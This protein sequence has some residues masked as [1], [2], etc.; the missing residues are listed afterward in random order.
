MKNK[1]ID[2]LNCF[3]FPGNIFKYRRNSFNALLLTPLNIGV[4]SY[5]QG[6]IRHIRINIST[7]HVPCPSFLRML[8]FFHCSQ[9]CLKPA[10]CPSFTKITH[11]IYEVPII[12][13]S[14]SI[15]QMTKISL[16]TCRSWW[17]MEAAIGNRIRKT[18][19]LIRKN[20]VWYFELL[21]LMDEFESTCVLACLRPNTES[22]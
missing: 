11:Y 17:E 8:Q 6:Q 22:V 12:S 3:L 16:N 13:S 5:E 21:E 10:V 18:I 4:S 14:P 15:L 1:H 2:L 9:L 7:S 19:I 20:K